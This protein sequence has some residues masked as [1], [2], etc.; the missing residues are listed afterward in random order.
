MLAI[1]HNKDLTSL[2]TFHLQ[3]QAANYCILNSLELLPEIRKHLADFPGY[4]IL[5]GGSNILLPE[6]YNGLVIKNDLHGIKFESVND[7]FILATAAAGEV[8]DDFVAQ[9]V[10]YGAYGLEN[11]SLIPGTV[12]ASPVQ[13]IGAYGVEVKDFIDYVTVYDLV[14]GE[15]IEIPNAECGFSY[16]NSIFKRKANYL[17]VSVTF[18]LST[19]SQLKLSY[20]DLAKAFAEQA[21]PTPAQVRQA[22]IDIRRNK[23][24]DPAQIGNVGSFFH[25]PIVPDD[26]AK[27]LASDF[28]GL[29][30]YPA[31]NAGHKK[32]SAGWLIDKLGLKGH[33]QGNIAVYDKQALVLVNH[34]TATQS[35]LLA[36]AQDIQ[37]RVLA[38]YGV[39]I[40][41]EPIIV[42]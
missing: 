16:R 21:N 34:A 27:Q 15:M 20:A 39:N 7:D 12:G 22:V 11:L 31:D 14:S 2:N 38:A 24:P 19:I 30:I 29:P 9:T 41:I 23:L 8:W 36:F 33:R 42:K 4:L 26:I 17:V 37:T 6:C 25:N 18:R 3:S 1:Q 13:N 35:E 40:N 5:G 32:V 28:P 10:S